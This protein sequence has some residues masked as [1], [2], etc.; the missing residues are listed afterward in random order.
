MAA[1]YYVMMLRNAEKERRRQTILQ[2]LPA[3]SKEY[4]DCFHKL[5]SMRDWSNRREFMEKHA[6]DSENLRDVRLPR[7]HLQHPRDPTQ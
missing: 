7:K 4:Y 1:F 5:Q 6:S 3:M 2:K